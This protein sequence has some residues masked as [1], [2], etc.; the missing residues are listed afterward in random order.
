MEFRDFLKHRRDELGISQAELADRLSERG[1][2]ASAARV[3]HWETG[4]NKPPLDDPKFRLVIASTLEIDV[5][6][7]MMVLGYVV[8]DENRSQEAR[9]AADIVDRLPDDA[10]ELALD[11]LDVLERRY[12]KQLKHAER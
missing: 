6:E 5:N 2:E 4:R 8:T 12:L 7:M 10:R 9:R 3:G 1:E 11:Y